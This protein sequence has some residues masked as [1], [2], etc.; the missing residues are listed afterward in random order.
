LVGVGIKEVV[1]G[2]DNGVRLHFPR[3]G[4]IVR[5]A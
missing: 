1:L 3:Q 5:A 4:Y 2:L